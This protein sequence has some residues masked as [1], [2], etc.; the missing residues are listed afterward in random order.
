MDIENQVKEVL[1][2]FK[3]LT[4]NE[5]E[6]KIIGRIY[7]LNEDYYE[8]EINFTDFPNSLPV[9][10]ELLTRIPIKADRHTYTD[11]GSLCFTTRANAE[12]LLKTKI[13]TL[14]DFINHILIP[15]LRNNS[16]YEIHNKYFS[17]E[18]SHGTLGVMESYK[19][20]LMINDNYKIARLILDRIEGRNLKF[21]DLCYCNSNLP[22]K[23]CKNGKHE[24]AYR[25]FK[26]ISSDTLTNDLVK[27]IEFLKLD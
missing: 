11:N 24:K 9:V 18:Y 16:Y 6:K 23:K 3:G 21:K 20:I 7:I 14:K 12:I 17:N 13:K 1:T 22:L 2:F 15:Y 4:Y 26:L 25:T 10:K 27:I 5:V 8:V 19:D